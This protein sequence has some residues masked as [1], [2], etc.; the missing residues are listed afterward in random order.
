ML[1]YSEHST[2]GPPSPKAIGQW[3]RK[4]S[5]SQVALA[6]SRIGD[7]L[8]E[9]GYEPSGFP[10][11]EIT[12]GRRMLLKVQDRVNRAR[13]RRNRYGTLLH[14][15]HFASRVGRVRPV[16]DW[17]NQRIQDIDAKYIK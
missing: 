16:L 4:L 2:Y 5:P 12:P 1:S 8:Q 15:A 10:T 13:F 9:R 6:E 7:M 11:L 14:A 3:K 17:T